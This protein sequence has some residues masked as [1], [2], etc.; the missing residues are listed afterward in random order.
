[1]LEDDGK[2]LASLRAKADQH[3]RELIKEFGENCAEFSEAE[4]LAKAQADKQAAP[5]ELIG[6]PAT[7]G[8]PSQVV[9][10]GS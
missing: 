10:A 8:S 7:R 5:I 4:H 1:M 3:Q 6:Q 9:L 2:P